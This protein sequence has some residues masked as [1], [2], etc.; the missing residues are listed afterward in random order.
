MK[1]NPK[2]L[3]ALICTAVLAHTVSAEP[4]A[5]R[6]YIDGAATAQQIQ[7][8]LQGGGF[9]PLTKINVEAR[10]DGVVTLKGVAVSDAEAVRATDLAKKVKGV[11]DVRS[12]IS[13]K[14]I[15]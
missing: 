1:R 5:Q 3:F 10:D 14:R 4:A 13:V 8:E 6:Q 15:Q 11:I 12:E 7:A 9:S 2:I